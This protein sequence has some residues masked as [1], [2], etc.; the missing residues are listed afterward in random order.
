MCVFL[1]GFG[2]NDRGEKAEGEKQG[3]RRI[4]LTTDPSTASSFTG[5]SWDQRAKAEPWP[6]ERSEVRGAG[7]TEVFLPDGGVEKM[8]V[9]QVNTQSWGQSQSTYGGSER[10]IFS[11]EAAQR[12]SQPSVS[13]GSSLGMKADLHEHQEAKAENPLSPQTE[14]ERP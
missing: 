1:K 12:Q 7:A 11:R 10:Q 4:P 6:A 5:T 8:E 9:Q 14:L 2:L 3:R 13:D